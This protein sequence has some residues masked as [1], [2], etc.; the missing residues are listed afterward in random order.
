MVVS[1]S[2]VKNEANGIKSE[3][4]EC[5]TDTIHAC[6]KTSNGNNISNANH[7]KNPYAGQHRDLRKFSVIDCS[8]LKEIVPNAEPVALD[9]ECFSGHVFLLVRTPDVDDPNEDDPT[10]E[11]ALRTSKYLKNFKRRFEFQF[12]IKLS[13]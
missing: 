4:I 9:N 12:Q 10:L 13:E 11:S 6:G 7:R 3:P 2:D 8:N 1:S 5:A